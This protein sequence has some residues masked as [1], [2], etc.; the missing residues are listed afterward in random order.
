MADLQ[1]GKAFGM[2]MDALDAEIERVN[3]T[4]LG[5]PEYD[6]DEEKLAE[7][8]ARFKEMDEDGSGD[9][10]ILELG[11]AMEKL[12]K[13]KNQLE[14]RKMIAEV[15]LDGSNTINYHEFITMMVGRSSSVLRLILLFEGMA[16]RAAEEARPKGPPPKRSLADLP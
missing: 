2:R 1:G 9:I 4:F 11:R 6:V 14:L 3:S 15:D 13:P 10:D 12:G 16:A 8:A 7:F 5:D